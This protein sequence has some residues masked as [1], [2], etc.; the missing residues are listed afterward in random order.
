MV[1]RNPSRLIMFGGAL[2]LLGVVAS[3]AMVLRLVET[4]F[5]FVFLTYAGSVI[6]GLLGTIGIVEYASQRNDWES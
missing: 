4:T 6:G 2:L 1:I 5:W 3:F